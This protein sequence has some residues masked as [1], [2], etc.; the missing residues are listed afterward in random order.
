MVLFP[1]IVQI[2]KERVPNLSKTSVSE[3]TLIAKNLPIQRL[4]S[5]IVPLVRIAARSSKFR[6]CDI[7]IMQL[8]KVIGMT[9]EQTYRV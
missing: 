3:G 1:R 7:H 5:Y 6:Y 8:L 4:Q 9:L 2:K